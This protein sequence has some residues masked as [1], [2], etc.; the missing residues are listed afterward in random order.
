MSTHNLDINMYSFKDIL[1]LFDITGDV[2]I[3]DLKRAKKKVLMLHPDKSKL[4]ADYFLFYKKAYEIIY[5]FYED[6]VKQS[7][8]VPNEEVKYSAMNE[9]EQMKNQMNE[10]MKNMKAQEFHQKFNTMFEKNMMV[11]PDESKNEWFR[12]E[13]PQFDLS[14]STTKENMASRFD[15]IKQQNKLVKYNGVKTLNQGGTSLYDEETDEYINCDPFSKLKFDDLRK[16][17]KDE[18]VIAVSEKDFNNVQTY[19]SVD[20]LQRVRK[21]DSLNPMEKTQAEKMM[22]IRRKE[23]E[24]LIRQKQYQ[25]TLQTMENEKKNQS[26]LASFLRLTN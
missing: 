22:E 3:E 15:Q 2:E 25:S 9:S 4:P 26:I 16:V 5:Y 13:A 19:H 6:K 12:S 14:S 7:K 20:Q 11:K 10:V 1:N 8:I 21:Q 17:H 24:E 18:T 23:K